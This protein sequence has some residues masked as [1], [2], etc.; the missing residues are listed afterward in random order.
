MKEIISEFPLLGSQ[1]KQSQENDARRAWE[2][3]R[4]TG[5]TTSWTSRIESL[6]EIIQ[7]FPGGLWTVEYQ[8][9]RKEF[10]DASEALDEVFGKA[11]IDV[12][13]AYMHKNIQE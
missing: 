11:T 1:S 12:V 10:L 13:K 2:E 8:T 6:A 3:I 4:L 5:T 9:W 7:R